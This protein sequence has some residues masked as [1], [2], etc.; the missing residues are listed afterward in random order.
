M[1]QVSEAMNARKRLL[2]AL[3]GIA[4]LVLSPGCVCAGVSPVQAQSHPCCPS[5][6][7]Q[8]HGNVS[9]AC[10]CIDRQPAAPALPPLA[11]AGAPSDSVISVAISPDEATPAS[12]RISYT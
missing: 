5:P 3:L 1:Q 4:L 11:V 7:P 9:A 12:G 2:L 6:S 8:H 10:I